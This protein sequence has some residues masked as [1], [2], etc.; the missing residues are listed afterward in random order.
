MPVN[1]QINN[2]KTLWRYKFIFKC[3]IDNIESMNWMHIWGN[4]GSTVGSVVASERP[5]FDSHREY[6]G[7]CVS[8]LHVTGKL[9][10]GKVFLCEVYMFSSYLQEVSTLEPNSPGQYSTPLVNTGAWTKRYALCHKGESLC[11]KWSANRS[12]VGGS[13]RALLSYPKKD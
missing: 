6:Y 12:C 9:I 3:A 8:L 13:M 11:K 5:Q 4:G 1:S 7:R 2:H 10:M